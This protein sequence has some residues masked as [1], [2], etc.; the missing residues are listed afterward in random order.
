MSFIKLDQKSYNS[1][2]TLI[3]NEFIRKYVPDTD[4]RFI[5]VYLFGLY[6]AGADESV[7]TPDTIASAL[8]MT[9]DDILAAFAFWEET[10]LCLVTENPLSVIY[11]PLEEGTPY[12]KIKPTKYRSFNKAMQS[13]ITD[14]MI[15][16]AEFNEYY[17]FMEDNHFEPEALVAVARYCVSVKNADVGYKYI[18]TV[19]ANMCKLGLRNVENV[20]ARLSTHDKYSDKLSVLFKIL[21]LRRSFEYADRE[22]CEKWTEDYGFDFNTVC[23]VAKNCKR[24]EMEKL[25][26]TLSDY[27]RNRLLSLKEIELFEADRNKNRELAR[28][29]N[30]RMGNYYQN[31]DFIVEDYITRWLNMGF[32]SETLI[33]LAKYAATCSVRTLEGLDNIVEKL[34]K[35]GITTLSAINRYISDSASKNAA[36]RKI[37]ESMGIERRANSSDIKNYDMWIKKGLSEDVIAYAAQKCAGSYNPLSAWNKLLGMYAANGADTV[38]KAEKLTFVPH[39]KKDEK[40]AGFESH[41]YTREELDAMFEALGETD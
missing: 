14:R 15:T 28:E 29:I 25:D 4:P 27:F 37:L 22:L 35:A 19:A 34:F 11:R 18:L 24:G 26:R 36:V 12:K 8:N 2:Y 3:P 32:D 33:T 40:F 21:G 16:P 20:T 6:L 31:V 1:L 38:E 10:G 5:S 7:N 30:R 23:A 17:L 13:V 39:G 9:P 41:E